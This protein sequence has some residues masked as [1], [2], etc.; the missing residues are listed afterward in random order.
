MHSILV[1]HP[2][3]ETQHECPVFNGRC[4]KRPVLSLRAAPLTRPV[5]R[6]L[7]SEDGNC[8]VLSNSIKLAEERRLVGTN[9]RPWTQRSSTQPETWLDL[10]NMSK[11]VSI[12]LRKRPNE[13]RFNCSFRMMQSCSKLSGWCLNRASR[14]SLTVQPCMCWF[15]DESGQ[16][17][18]NYLPF[19][20][21]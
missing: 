9:T 11:Y 15:T 3:S 21:V 6:K 13:M 2:A 19:P 18:N 5:W 20:F 14:E 10:K 8:S 17:V 4:G 16:L 7:I 1:K 12:S